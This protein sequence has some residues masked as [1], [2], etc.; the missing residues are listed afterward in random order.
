ME[1]QSPAGHAEYLLR[2]TVTDLEVYAHFM[3]DQL[4]AVQGIASI[5][6]SFAFG[7]IKSE[8]IQYNAQ[9]I[10]RVAGLFVKKYV[11]MS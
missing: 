3:R 1:L 4:D 2:V 6:S 11:T 8:R 7:K 5:D 9:A 10:R